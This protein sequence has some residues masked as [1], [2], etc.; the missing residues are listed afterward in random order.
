MDNNVKKVKS[1]IFARQKNT[2]IALAVIFA[3]LLCAYIFIIRPLMKDDSD[4]ASAP[5]SLIWENEVASS[6][7][8]MMFEHIER[9]SVSEI[10]VHNPSLLSKYGEQYVDW[11]IYRAAK[12][13]NVGGATIEKGELYLK[14]YEYAPLDDNDTD[15]TI[16]AIINDAGFPLA[17]SRV[18]DHAEDF[19]KYGLDFESDEDAIYCE[20]TTVDNKIYKFYVGDKIPSG[21]A[22]YVRMAGKD[23]CTDKESEFY[24]QEIENDSVYIYD[25]TG[26]LVSPTDAVSPILT[27]P[28]NTSLQ[29][30]FN[31]FEIADYVDNTDAA[32]DD[33]RKKETRV[34]LMS[35]KDK[36]YL[37]KPISAFAQEAIYYTSIPTGYNSSSAFEDLFESFTNGLMGA[38]VREL[39]TLHDGVDEETGKSYKY[40]GFDDAVRDKYFEGGAACTL[41]FFWNNI[42]NVIVVSNLTENG[43]YYVYSLVYNTICEVDADT[44]SFI[45]W[46]QS[47]FIDRN[48]FRVSIYNCS[49]FSVYGTYYDFDSDYEKKTVDVSF[50]VETDSNN[51]QSVTSESFSANGTMSASERTENFRELYTIMMLSALG[52]MLD[53]NEVEE[54]LKGEAFAEIRVSTRKH[55]ATVS[56]PTAEDSKETTVNVPGMTRIYRFYKYSTGRCLVTTADVI[57]GEES[58][59]TGCF[60]MMTASVEQILEAAENV[61]NDVPV[62]KYE[63]Y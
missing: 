50:N 7:G 46:D 20:I 37:S 56:D 43:T 36:S 15:S 41:T 29:A 40:Y 27:Y 12:D 19:S 8:I 34:K 16:A 1:S 23:V 22:Y 58:K 54:I 14:G 10:K 26:I 57:E 45:R 61:A 33:E 55:T 44:L 49:N 5:I 62:S 48:F 32:D 28:L 4:A 42:E 25:C 47:M 38:T 24:G 39:A 17:L 51:N 35:T 6:G 53:E 2:I 63:R 30:Y 11:S 21:T 18:T 31:S 9:N 52:E 60:Y 59:E 13:E 3:V